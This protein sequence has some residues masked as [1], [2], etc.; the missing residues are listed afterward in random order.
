[1]SYLD[2]LI[3]MQDEL[4]QSSDISTNHKLLLIGFIEKERSLD[5]A[6]EDSFVYFYSNI[7]KS[8][9]I[10]DFSSVL[11][12][13]YTQAQ[14]YANVCVLIFND[15]SYLKAD[16]LLQSWLQNAIKFVDCIVIHYLQE[17]LNEE[18]IA[19]ENVGVERSRYRQ[20]NKKGVKAERAGRIMD[21]LYGDRNKMEHTTNPH[22][23]NP[24]MQ[25]LTPPKYNK[26]KKNIQKRFPEALESFNE[27]FKEYYDAN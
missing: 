10:F 13:N 2:T 8:A 16:P 11:N 21:N 27:A 20:I 22:P 19:Q 5:Y 18:P 6:E 15:F 9:D 26:V 4:K 24:K 12:E 23:K 7:L 17:V 3:E 14:S 1:M 25:V